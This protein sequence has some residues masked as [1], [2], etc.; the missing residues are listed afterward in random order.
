[1]CAFARACLRAVQSPDRFVCVRIC[2]SVC[3]CV[4]VSALVGMRSCVRERRCDSLVVCCVI[5]LAGLCVCVLSA[6]VYGVCVSMCDCPW[7]HPC[8]H[9]RVCVCANLWRVTHLIT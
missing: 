7:L 8:A 1:V 3:A 2:E 9:A 5:A 4:C 6:L